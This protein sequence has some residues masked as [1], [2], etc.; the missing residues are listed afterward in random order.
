MSIANYTNQT[1]TWRQMTGTNAYGE[2]ETVDTA[3]PVRWEWRRRMVRNTEGVDVVSEG[4]V[5][6]AAQVAVGDSLIEPDGTSYPV[7]AVSVLYDLD[8]SER[9]REV[10]V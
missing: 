1:A 7:I 10:S 4:T 2:P 5:Y 8:G 9:H 3:I 6:T